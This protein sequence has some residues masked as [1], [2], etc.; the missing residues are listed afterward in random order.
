MDGPA[1]FYQEDARKLLRN[2]KI[3][4]VGDS[5]MRSLYKDIL[6]LIRKS[7]LATL[8]EL[9][10]KAEFSFHDDKTLLVSNDTG[11]DFKE[12]R[13]Y[14]L[15][16]FDITYAFVAKCWPNYYLDDLFKKLKARETSNPTILIMSSLLWDVS[17]YEPGSVQKYKESL[18]E[19]V[20][21][22]KET[23]EPQQFL[24]LTSPPVGN[25]ITASFLG[26]T[27]EIT[28]EMC[29]FQ[30]RLGRQ[31]CASLMEKENLDFFDLYYHMRYLSDFRCKDETHWTSNGVRLM[32][33][34]LLTH[35][36]IMWKVNPPR[37]RPR[38]VALI[39]S[40]TYDSLMKSLNFMREQEGAWPDWLQRRK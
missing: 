9:K 7:R 32:V 27:A 15:G 37:L 34:Y 3:I 11:L 23:L 17:R 19:L 13:Q 25:A 16:E 29:R 20:K 1:I 33:N 26:H 8:D 35:L 28:K 30:V 6:V 39:E 18:Q 2:K 10:S 38:E 31:W 21:Q 5:N 24:W 4:L 22:V 36:C 40:S 12:V 14:N